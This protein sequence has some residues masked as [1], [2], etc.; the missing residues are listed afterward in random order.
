M[1]KKVTLI[2]A[3]VLCM[4]LFT[5]CGEKEELDVFKEQMND[6]YTEVFSVFNNNK[7]ITFILFYLSQC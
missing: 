5:G 7:D 2:I 3:L 4:S 1:F 6:F